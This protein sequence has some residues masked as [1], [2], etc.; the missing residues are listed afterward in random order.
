[1]VTGINAVTFSNMY[2]ST[3]TDVW[4]VTL[5]VVCLMCTNE[6]AEAEIL[7]VQWAGLE[8]SFRDD[9]VTID[10]HSSGEAINWS[11]KEFTVNNPPR[12]VTGFVAISENPNHV[13]FSLPSVGKVTRFM[14][15]PVHSIFISSHA[16]LIR[17]STRRMKL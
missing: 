9:F 17:I 2:W 4:T 11:R 7:K 8:H 16:Q 10:M 1:M 14:L 3:C 15:F 13:H 5:I 12:R 6:F